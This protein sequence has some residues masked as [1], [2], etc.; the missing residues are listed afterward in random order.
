MTANI[1]LP[2]PFCGGIAEWEYTDWNESDESG[3]DGMGRIV[4][5]S[6]PAEMHG[7]RDDAENKW[8]SRA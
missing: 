3:D 8:N 7:D 6:C 5:Q 1:L 4:C 2:C